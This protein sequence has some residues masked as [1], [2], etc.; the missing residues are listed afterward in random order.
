MEL[1][2]RKN[3][4]AK[5]RINNREVRCYSRDKLRKLYPDGNYTL[6]GETCKDN[7]KRA[8]G[9]ITLAKKEFKVSKYR[10]H[11]RILYKE[12]GFLAVGKNRYVVFLESRLMFLLI[13]LALILA[14]V[15]L[16]LLGLH[17]YFQTPTISPDYPL[18]PEDEGATVIF[19]DRTVK[20]ESEGGAVRVR[21]N[22]LVTIDLASGEIALT[23]QNPNQ[24]NRDSVVTL[25]L[26]KDNE[27]YIIARSGLVKAG[28]QIKSMQLIPGVVKL[29][30]GG[31]VGKLMIDHYDPE[32]GEKA[33]AG[34]VFSEIEI[35]VK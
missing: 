18:P 20:D 17:I 3:Y 27:E 1:V 16:V 22:R 12:V 26:V 7:R 6:A 5:I 31:Y 30:Q 34:A 10:T 15:G 9:K 23:Y 24:S 4:D 19:G 32:T 8:I 25:A 28:A 33:V 14:G 35:Q 29:T 13:L 2:A 21:F 11:S